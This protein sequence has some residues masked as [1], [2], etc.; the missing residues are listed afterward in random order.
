MLAFMGI[1]RALRAAVPLLLLAACAGGADGPAASA[2]CAPYADY[3]G[4]RGS[5]VKVYSSI[6]DVEQQRSG[7]RERLEHLA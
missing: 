1:L 5:T 2:S 4:H 6:R 3:Q 7:G